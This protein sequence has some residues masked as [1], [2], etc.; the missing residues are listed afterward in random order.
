MPGKGLED[1][2]AEVFSCTAGGSTVGEAFSAAV[3]QAQWEHGHGGY[4]GTIAEKD[5]WTMVAD[6]AMTLNDAEELGGRLVDECDE[7]IDNK[8]GPAGAI[9]LVEGGWYFFGWAAS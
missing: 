3:E 2:G 6:E 5:S 7:R 8:H 1:M 9:Q 4:T